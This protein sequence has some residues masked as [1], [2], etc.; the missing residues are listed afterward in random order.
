[1]QYLCADAEQLPL[2]AQVIDDMFSNLACNGAGT[3]GVFADI[4][5]V[6]KADG[7]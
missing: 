6:L 2:A 1:V 7:S 5:R 4:K 3:R